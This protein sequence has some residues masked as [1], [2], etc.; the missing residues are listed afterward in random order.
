LIHRSTPSRRRQVNRTPASSISQTGQ[1]PDARDL[2]LQ[3]QW[4]MAVLALPSRFI[5]P[6]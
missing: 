4:L 5:C 1:Q 6:D 2:L 3:A